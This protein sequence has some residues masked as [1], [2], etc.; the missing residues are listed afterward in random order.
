MSVRSL[1]V[2]PCFNE[3]ERLDVAGF[4]EYLAT[5]PDVGF[6]LVDDGSTDDTSAVL[7]RVADG[8]DRV[9]VLRLERNAGK[10]EAVRRGIL[11]ALG[12]RPRLVGYWD[13]DL[14]TPLRAIAQLESEFAVDD[15]A[16][17]AMGARVQ[18][19]GRHIER[20]AAR[21]Y[22]GRVFATCASLALHL[23]VYDTQC[24]A[25][26]IRVTPRTRAV[27]DRPFSSRWIF[28]VELI[29]RLIALRAAAGESDHGVREVPLHAWTDIA[30]SKVRLRDGLRAFIDLARI[31]R[32]YPP[33]LA[34]W[35]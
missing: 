27:F 22:F 8:H 19:L 13:A 30:G 20:R 18:L 5:T 9:V 14:A 26:L 25:K 29:A 21:H 12:H 31:R 11:E 7:R 1:I 4:R 35:H 3:A 17:L 10:A 6:V 16:E 28:D 33:Q 15:A 34:A 2:V 32:A 23:P 24:G